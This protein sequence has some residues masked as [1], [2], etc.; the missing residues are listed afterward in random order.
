MFFPSGWKSFKESSSDH[1]ADLH[2]IRQKV[3]NFGYL[4]LGCIFI[5]EFAYKIIGIGVMYYS[6]V[7]PYK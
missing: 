1:A 4:A 7:F 5:A 3:G 6:E 2:N